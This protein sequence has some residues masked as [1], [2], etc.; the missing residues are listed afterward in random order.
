MITHHRPHNFDA[1]IFASKFGYIILGIF[2]CRG[3]RL[4]QNREGKNYARH[5]FC[6]YVFEIGNICLKSII[7]IPGEPKTH[8]SIMDFI[9]VFIAVLREKWVLLSPRSSDDSWLF[10]NDEWGEWFIIKEHHSSSFRMEDA[11]NNITFRFPEILKWSMKKVPF[12]HFS[13][14]LL[15]NL[16]KSCTF[17]TL[18]TKLAMLHITSSRV[19]PKLDKLLKYMIDENGKGGM[20]R[21]KGQRYQTNP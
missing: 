14:L 8:Y 13:F 4:R 21:S 3:R 5:P 20:W 6:S 10:M 16:F 18:T 15:S 17:V 7:T 9:L 1:F 2:N 11:T 19:S 12:V